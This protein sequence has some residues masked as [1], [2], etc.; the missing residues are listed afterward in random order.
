MKVLLR[1]VTT[2]PCAGDGFG[3]SPPMRFSVITAPPG[4]WLPPP[5]TVPLT[6]VGP[7]D[8]V[9]R[10]SC[11]TPAETGGADSGVVVAIGGSGIAAAPPARDRASLASGRIT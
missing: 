4:P 3:V 2:L 11:P 1:W 6:E 8:E 10:G 7:V 9:D 5:F